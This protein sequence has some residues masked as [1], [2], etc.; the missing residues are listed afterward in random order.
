MAKKR[1]QSYVNIPTEMLSAEDIL[2]VS[3]WRSEEAL[4][5]SSQL[6]SGY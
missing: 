6:V 2:K 1:R 5:G 4:G 3:G